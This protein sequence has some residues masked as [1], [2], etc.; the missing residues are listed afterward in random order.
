MT[1]SSITL[2]LYVLTART[3]IHT[4][5]LEPALRTR[6]FCDGN[7]SGSIGGNTELNTV[8]RER[9]VHGAEDGKFHR[10]FAENQK[11]ENTRCRGEIGVLSLAA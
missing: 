4:T 10:F 5:E 3:V 8:L 6:V 9:Q 1:N 7:L 11:K 2:P